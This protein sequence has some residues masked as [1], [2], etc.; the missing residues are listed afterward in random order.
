MLG[1]QCWAPYCYPGPW[2]LLR[3]TSPP[4]LWW[5]K[6][7][8][9][10]AFTQ[11][12]I[13]PQNIQKIWSGNLPPRHND[14]EHSTW[15]LSRKLNETLTTPMLL[16]HLWISECLGDKA[17]LLS[18][19]VLGEVG[20]LAPMA[21]F[22]LL[23]LPLLAVF[24]LLWELILH[25]REYKA[26]SPLFQEIAGK[27]ELSLLTVFGLASLWAYPKKSLEKSQAEFKVHLDI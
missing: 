4:L 15:H 19:E 9:C 5:E 24:I 3:E 27:L 25:Q 13:L 21:L 14:R 23:S 17:S 8:Y 22:S 7:A 16:L 18:R 11:V 26:L 10:P 1:P 12:F 6:A 20:A 2:Q